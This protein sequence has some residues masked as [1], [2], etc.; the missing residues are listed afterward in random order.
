MVLASIVSP[1]P[2]VAKAPA[3]AGAAHST[4]IPGVAPAAV[5]TANW[6]TYHHDNSRAGVDTG[7][8]TFSALNRA[9]TQSS[10]VGQIYASP[11]VYG[12]TVY[13]ATE[14]NYIYALDANNN[15]AVLWSLQLS[16]PEL[17][18]NLPCG[19]IS[20]NVG[21]TGTPVIDT[22]TNRIFAVG[23]VS[24]HHYVL[25]GVNLTTHAIDITTTVDPSSSLD[26]VY[27]QSQRGALAV[28]GGNVYIP[29]GGRAGDCNSPMGQ[30]YHGVVIAASASTG[31]L[32]YNFTTN[33]GQKGIWAPGGESV[34]AS[35]N[36][37]VA[38]GNGYG[39]TPND[40]E[41]TFELS[42]ALAVVHRWVPANQNALDSADADTGS[43]IPT[44]VGGGD[45]LQ[46]GKSGDSY[47]LDATLGQVQGPTHVCTGVTSDASYGAG[48]YLAPYI[49]IPCNNALYAVTQSGN[50]FSS[51]WS[52]PGV[53]ATSPIIAGG[54]V[55]ILDGGGST[56]FALNPTTGAQITSVSTG[57]LT[58]FASPATGDGMV[59]VPGQ[60]EIDAFSM[61]GCT[62]ASMSP[63]TASPQ[64][65]GATVTFTATATTCSTPE[66]KFFMQP[67]GGSWTAQ[68]A[69]GANT[70]AWNTT[71]LTPGVYGVGVW[72]RQTGSG[73]S[74]EAYWIGTYTLSVTTCTAA[75]ISTVTTSPQAPGAM[76][77]FTAAAT[78][79]AGAQFRFWMIPHGGVWTM[80]RDYGANTW[81]WNTTG[82]APGIYE[83]GVWAK[84]PG[85]T[86]AYDAYGFTTF[87]IGVGNCISA[88]M[89]PNLAPPQAPGATVIFTATSNSCTSPLYQF[90]LLRPGYGWQARQLYSAMATWSWDTNTWPLGTYQV[91]VWVKAS[92]SSAAYD[93]FFIGT[94]QLDVSPC[95]S[96]SISASP[97]SPQAPGGAITFTVTSTDCTAPTYEFWRMPPPG[98]AWSVTQPYS[99]VATQT[100]STT[101]AS[102]PYRIGVWAR[103]SGS[104]NSYD[105]YAIL[106]FWVGT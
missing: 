87:S 106:T 45:V 61:G 88:G 11:L 95:T 71:G 37:Y 64:A 69:F 48:A 52:F 18:S 39:G 60:N 44:L 8:P 47:L 81:L 66:F 93:A 54:A 63:G 10:L 16:L 55:L 4:S 2:A 68:T 70:W 75:T 90:W 50:T 14:D 3:S 102:G 36:V 56:L 53:N 32:L 24:T 73:A 67:P 59:F 34:D 76:I 46:N 77:T 78:R 41:T 9:W 74:Y 84:Q 15:G 96:A 85:S 105:S 31:A 12:G 28:S 20:P 13:V 80:Q 33:G 104:P 91:G 99:G 86:N 6:L 79:C 25:W 94:F 58:H 100:W 30:P 38:T 98:S 51:A 103:Q 23:D 7:E 26:V 42:P 19:N 72:A 49:Y 57:G 92:A 65:P 27:A 22:T 5:T 40:S 43:I 29:Y 1:V 62:S 35:G 82:L 17:A 83:L 97:A 21:I 101:G 89:S